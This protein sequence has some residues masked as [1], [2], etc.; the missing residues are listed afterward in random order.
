MTELMAVRCLPQVLSGG[1]GPWE[2]HGS[3]RRGPLGGVLVM[4]GM[5][6]EAENTQAGSRASCV[7]LKEH[8]LHDRHYFSHSS[9]MNQPGKYLW[10]HE[11]DSLVGKTE[12]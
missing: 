1:W 11:A 3:L 8:L 2:I 9:T 10:P 4:T 5:A 6:H 12:C 7:S